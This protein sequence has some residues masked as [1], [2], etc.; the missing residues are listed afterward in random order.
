ML[1][2]AVERRMDAL[3]EQVE[4]ARRQNEA[5]IEK[6]IEKEAYI[7]A[8]LAEVSAQRNDARLIEELRHQLAIERN[9]SLKILKELKPLKDREAR[10]QAEIRRRERT[11]MRVEED[12]R[13]RRATKGDNVVAIDPD[14]PF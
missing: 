13:K 12:K 11:K 7:K 5:L 6:L 8:R 9:F 1:S 3:V 4:H 2:R 10:R 14:R